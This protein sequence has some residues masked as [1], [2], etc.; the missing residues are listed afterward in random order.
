[1]AQGFA[2]GGLS[3]TYGPVQPKKPAVPTETAVK[4]PLPPPIMV[5]PG[6]PTSQPVTGAPAAAAPMIGATSPPPVTG[7]PA[8]AAP[9]L[10]GLTP[11]PSTPAGR[12]EGMP[13][14]TTQPVGGVPI[15]NGQIGGP[16]WAT[17]MGPGQVGGSGFQ[18][19]TGTT[20]VLKPGQNL[21]PVQGG[22]IASAPFNPTA[23]KP[24]TGQGAIVPFGPGNDLIGQQINPLADPRLQRT[25]GAVDSAVNAL[26]GGPDR[27]QLAQTYTDIWN[28]TTNPQY[29]ADLRRA[30]Q[31]ASANGRLGSGMLTTSYGDITANRDLQRNQAQ[32]GFLTEALGGT[33]QDRLNNVN[34]LTGV[35]GQQF[36]QGAA[37]RSEL[38]GERGYQQGLD[39]QG[40]QN[41]IQRQTLEDFLL[42]SQFGR[43]Q[44]QINSL[45]NYG[46]GGQNPAGAYLNA[47]GQQG[48]GATG[49]SQSVY[50]LLAQYFAGS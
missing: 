17:N 46:F 39:Q 2:P 40:L 48:A 32:R 50:D 4:V 45:L 23:G 28:Q 36:G 9:L 42:N 3:A 12:S 10:G 25:Q 22:P 47:S 8:A 24:S 6:Q 21:A 37:Q 30:T 34:A 33:I 18:P 7:V 14:A 1:M 49:A 15:T 43:D 44:S 11:P 27:A 31:L 19:W 38:R 16:G 29:E 20:P 5:N 35:E 41:E 13:W 26:Q